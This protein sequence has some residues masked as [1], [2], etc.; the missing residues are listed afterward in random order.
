MNLSA[1][2]E[3]KVIPFLREALGCE[4]VRASNV[5]ILNSICGHIIRPEGEADFVFRISEDEY[6]IELSQSVN[7]V[8]SMRQTCY[9]ENPLQITEEILKFV[10]EYAGIPVLGRIATRS[11]EFEKTNGTLTGINPELLYGEDEVKEE[12]PSLDDESSDEGVKELI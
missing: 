7:R 3:T 10:A 4:N 2:F 8:D 12:V 11:E 5:G 1:I 9:L 6:G